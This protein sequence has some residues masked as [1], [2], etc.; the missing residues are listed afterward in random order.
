MSGLHG[1]ASE[2]PYKWRFAGEPLVPCTDPENFVGRGPT[3]TTFFFFKFEGR[4]DQNTT[5][6]GTSSVRQQNVIHM[7]VRWR[8]DDDLTL[9]AGLVAL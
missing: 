2:T 6:S 8:A 9:N 5:I 3:S 7:A 4:Q 1:L